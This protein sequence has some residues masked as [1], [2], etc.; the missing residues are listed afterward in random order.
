VRWRFAG[1]AVHGLR[2]RLLRRL[3]HRRRRHRA[4]RM[5][6]SRP[7][8][9]VIVVCHANLCRSPFGALVLARELTSLG[10]THIRVD[11][12]GF[13]ATGR[14]SPE[15]AVL[16][17]AEHGIDL[18]THRSSQMTT[19]GLTATDLIIVMSAEQGM[20]A[21]WRGARSDGRMLVLGDLDP[22]PIIE[23]TIRDPY[24]AD[25]QVFKDCYDRIER[26]M[27]ELARII[28]QKK[29]ARTVTG[30]AEDRA[31]GLGRTT[32]PAT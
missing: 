22:E 30:P 5:I 3:V 21:R 23:R 15:M 11:S 25:A 1:R 12:A 13:V 9:G 8:S 17:A 2:D 18:S 26:C 6:G 28:A 14:P 31:R 16:T 29:V 32:R 27:R 10:A 20:D 24:N 4:T 19:A 7:V